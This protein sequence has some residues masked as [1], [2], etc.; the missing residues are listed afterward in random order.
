MT[1]IGAWGGLQKTLERLQWSLICFSQWE[2]LMGAFDP[3]C[4]TYCSGLQPGSSVLG[5]EGG[6]VVDG[7]LFLLLPV[8]P[9][10]FFLNVDHFQS[11]Y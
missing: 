8:G 3:D 2:R 6:W 10:R 11:L 9:L 4:V 7:L 1:F 5:A